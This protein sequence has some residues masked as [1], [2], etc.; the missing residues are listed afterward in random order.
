MTL[1]KESGKPMIQIKDF[2]ANIE[3]AHEDLIQNCAFVK[4]SK[5]D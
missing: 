5:P 3:K 4:H 1:S 2:A